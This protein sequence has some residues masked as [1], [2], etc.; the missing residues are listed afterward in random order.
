MPPFEPRMMTRVWLYAYMIG[1]RSSRGVER[2]L[3]E[4]VPFRFLTGNQQPKY[5]ALNQF[6]SRH[7]VALSGLFE[8]SVKLASSLDL[9]GLK[10]VAVDGTKLKANAS[11]SKAMSYARM[12]KEEERLQREIEEYFDACDE[13]DAAEDEEYGDGDGYSLPEHLKRPADR[14]E[15]IRKAK[16]ELER[17]ARERAEA[18]QNARREAA[19][20]EGREFHPRSDPEE[21]KP[22]ARAQRNFTD[23][24]SRIMVSGGAFVQGYNAQ[25]AVDADHQVIVETFVTNQAADAPHLPALLEGVHRNAGANPDEVSADAGYFSEANLDAI[26]DAGATAFVPPEKVRHNQWREQRPPVGRIPK[27]ASRKDLMR[28]KLRTK[29]GRASYLL[30]Q[31]T[32]EPPFGQIKSGRGMC[33]A[34][35]RGLE[36]V[37]CFWRFDCAVHNFLKIMRHAVRGKTLKQALQAP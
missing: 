12:S 2:A 4:Q 31:V 6:R 5:W 7:R 37:N 29:A 14:L 35:H 17:E 24:E 28:R 25:T 20:T 36:K 27:N 32:A 21:A 13:I 11:K 9:V 34:L 26:E 15:A 23:P 3:V 22:A 18:E 10:H 19:A 16:E 30:R 33:Q 8:Q 1:L